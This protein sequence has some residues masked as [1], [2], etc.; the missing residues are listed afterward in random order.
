MRQEEVAWRG[1]ARLARVGRVAGGG[2]GR[3]WRGGVYY[4]GG[5]VEGA[6]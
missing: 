6:Q 3:R 2:C 1:K 5:G 4:V